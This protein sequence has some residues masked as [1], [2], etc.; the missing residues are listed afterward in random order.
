MRLDLW[1]D[2]LPDEGG[3]EM[4]T[5]S[6]ALIS[7]AKCTDEWGNS[8]E[9]K[10]S[11]AGSILYVNGPKPHEIEKVTAQLNIK[12]GRKEFTL[13][14]KRDPCPVLFFGGAVCPM[15]GGDHDP[16]NG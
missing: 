7:Y 5:I 2:R 9:G 1:N 14:V 6:L 16:S 13:F 3:Y 12:E 11:L 10:E 4:V 8:P 15:C